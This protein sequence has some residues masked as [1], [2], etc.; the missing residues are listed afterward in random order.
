MAQGIYDLLEETLKLMTKLNK[1]LCCNAPV[2]TTTSTTTIPP[3]TTTTTIGA[4][5]RKFWLV[6]YI[7]AGRNMFIPNAT[8]FFTGNTVANIT[9]S[10][11]T[12]LTF[13]NIVGSPVTGSFSLNTT[14]TIK[15][16]S[17][18]TPVTITPTYTFN[19]G[20]GTPIIRSFK[21]A[22]AF[23][24]KIVNNSFLATRNPQI[25]IQRVSTPISA[26]GISNVDA[27]FMIG[28][29]F[30][31]TGQEIDGYTKSVRSYDFVNIPGTMNIATFTYSSITNS[32]GGSASNIQMDLISPSTSWV[33]DV[34]VVYGNTTIRENFPI[35]LGW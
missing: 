5:T 21:E 4:F 1:K 17:S 24:T 12:D 29:D 23:V 11:N 8:A 6:D 32:G 33:N 10:L 20:T 31:S 15:E 9:G 30:D 19:D 13:M 3:T 34:T 27:F 22:Y 14:R 26:L 2:S 7:Y 28:V 35:P 18:A 16:N 25:V